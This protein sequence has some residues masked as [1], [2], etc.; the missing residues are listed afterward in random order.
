MKRNRIIF[1]LIIAISCITILLTSCDPT[2]P[3]NPNEGEVITSLK[4]SAINGDT[5]TFAYSDPDGNGG[6]PPTI[7]TIFLAPSFVYYVSLELLDETKNPVDTL[8]NEI[9]DEGDE[10]QFFFT[11]T[12]TLNLVSN[13]ADADI[14]S[15]PIGL[16]NNWTTG[17]ASTGSLIVTL[18]HQPDGTKDG[19]ITTGDTDVEV[20]FPVV[21]Q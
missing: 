10:H 8:T 17:A 7:D 16:T 2:A 5:L 11:T 9:L 3:P 12:L 20:A 18:K 6:N 21:I 19:N 15:D 1:N 4:I 14:N 13:Y